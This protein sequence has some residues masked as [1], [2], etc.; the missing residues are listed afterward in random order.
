MRY[1]FYVSVVV[2]YII[3]NKWLR[4]LTIYKDKQVKFI[5]SRKNK[6]IWNQR[7]KFETWE[8]NFGYSPKY[9]FTNTFI[10]NGKK[11]EIAVKKIIH[12]QEVKNKDALANPESLDYFVGILYWEWI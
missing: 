11:V 7:E 12:G 9:S 10:T 5:K 4:A 2:L 1:I 8:W 6:Q 3:L